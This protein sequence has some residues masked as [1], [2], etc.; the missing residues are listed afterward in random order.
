VEVLRGQVPTRDDTVRGSVDSKSAR[1]RGVG[2]DEGGAPPRHAGQ[3]PECRGQ[4]LHLADVKFNGREQISHL[5][6]LLL[7]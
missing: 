5:P 1:Q 3:S 6:E 4:Q 2:Q 7:R